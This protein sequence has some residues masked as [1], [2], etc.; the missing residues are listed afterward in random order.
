[1]GK[2]FVLTLLY[3]FVILYQLETLHNIDIRWIF[4][5]IFEL[6]K[7]KKINFITIITMTKKEKRTL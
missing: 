4:Y 1:M 3:L 5:E 2:F 7:D 6:N